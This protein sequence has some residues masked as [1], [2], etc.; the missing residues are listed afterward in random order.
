MIEQLLT[1]QGHTRRFV[2]E[3]AQAGGW[4]VKEELDSQV[5]SRARYHD[6][7]RVEQAVQLK[8]SLLE[9]DGWCVHLSA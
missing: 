9:R 5:L 4:E 2:I 3:H 7:H 8:V 6:W 1:H